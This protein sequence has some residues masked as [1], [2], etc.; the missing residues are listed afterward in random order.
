[1]RL[2]WSS[3]FA[4]LSQIIS[5]S[6][7]WRRNSK[8]SKVRRMQAGARPST[9]RPEGR[10]GHL[11]SFEGQACVGSVHTDLR[12]AI[13]DDK[14]YKNLEIKFE[15][16]RRGEDRRQRPGKA[17]A[18]LRNGPDGQQRVYSRALKLLQG[19][20]GALW[21]G[22]GDSLQIM[23]FQKKSKSQHQRIR[24]QSEPRSR[25]P[26]PPAAL[27]G[28]PRALTASYGPREPVWGR[29]WHPLPQRRT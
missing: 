9:A 11:T 1:M 21:L 15:K 8:C 16:T 27:R 10:R 7:G 24:R 13:V 25:P 12:A 4:R 6:T 5:R 17:G 26:R 20:N 14:K 2:D 28:L 22:S 29:A 3:D 18:D 23:D 19:R